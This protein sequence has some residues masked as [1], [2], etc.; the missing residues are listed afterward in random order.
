MF[1][2]LSKQVGASFKFPTWTRIERRI[3][4]RAR[5][6]RL[7]YLGKSLQ[8]LW[9][10][11]VSSLWGTFCFLRKSSVTG[12]L[13]YWYGS[14]AS[15]LHCDIIVVL[16]KGTVPRI[17]WSLRISY[18]SRGLKI[19]SNTVCIQRILGLHKFIPMVCSSSFFCVCRIIAMGRIATNKLR[20][21]AHHHSANAS[22][23]TCSTTTQSQ[24][25]PGVFEFSFAG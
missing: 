6:R 2:C 21:F 8:T 4:N 10:N 11:F 23:A 13:Q 9:M 22:S 1:F 15:V 20:P 5:R 17:F 12:S 18:V 7:W 3:R 14:V 19:F 24:G 16:T 25:L